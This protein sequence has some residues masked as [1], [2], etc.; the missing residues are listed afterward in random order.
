MVGYP[1]IARKTGITERET[2]CQV[3]FDVLVL[4]LVLVNAVNRPYRE[5]SEV[6]SNLNKDGIVLFLVCAVSLCPYTL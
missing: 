1:C 3:S 6:V 2:S 4:I 5:I